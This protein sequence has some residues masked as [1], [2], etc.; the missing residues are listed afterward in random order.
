MRVVAVADEAEVAADD[1][2]VAATDHGAAVRV[3]GSQASVQVDVAFLEVLSR[4]RR[5]LGDVRGKI[6]VTDAIGL[7][8]S[9]R[10]SRA[11]SRLIARALRHLGWQRGRYRFAGVLTYAYAKGTRLQRETILDVERGA[12]GLFVVKRMKMK[13]GPQARRA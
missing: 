12:D 11:R 1:H 7:A 2:E 5:A 6:R 13:R 10:R 9:G 3:A 8:G 4:L